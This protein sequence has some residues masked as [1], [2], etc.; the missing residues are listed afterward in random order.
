MEYATKAF[1]FS[2]QAHEKSVN[3]LSEAKSVAKAT[4]SVKNKK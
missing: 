3:F 2:Q 1:Q 4:P